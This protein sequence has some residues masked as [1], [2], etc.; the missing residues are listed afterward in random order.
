MRLFKPFLLLII[1]CFNVGSFFF[2]PDNVLAADTE[3]FGV[4]LLRNPGFEQ[5]LSR[6]TGWQW[7]DADWALRDRRSPFAGDASG[8]LYSAEEQR[9][10]AWTQDGVPLQAGARYLLAGYVRAD[11]PAVAFLGVE[12]TAGGEKQ[13]QRLHRGILPDSSWQKVELEFVAPVTTDATVLFGGVVHG[14]LWWDAVTLER[15]D[16]RTQKLAEQ[17]EA[18]LA[19]HGEVYTGLIIDARGLGLQRGM[20][21][22]IVDERGNVLYAGEGADRGVIMGLGLVSY[23]SDPNEALK[24]HRLAVHERFPYTVPLIVPAVDVVDDPFRVSVVIS[25]ADAARIRRELAK[26]DFLGRHAVVFVLDRK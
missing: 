4:N 17:W 15:V 19:R 3:Q 16:D 22:K 8:L 7:M 5:G 25:V 13:G 12:W 18:L 24:H 26:Y 10:L 2:L 14:S 1:L 20:S 21:P 6:P 23:M 11:T 9:E